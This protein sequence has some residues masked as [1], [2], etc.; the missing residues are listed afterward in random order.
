M[1]DNYQNIA[2]NSFACVIF[3][4]FCE[5]RTFSGFGA[6]PPYLRLHA[7]ALRS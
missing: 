5:M 3:Q 1:A 6:K 4:F 7:G 2:K